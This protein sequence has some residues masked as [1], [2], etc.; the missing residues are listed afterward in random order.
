VFRDPLALD[1]PDPDHSSYEERYIIIGMTSRGRP[2]LIWYT[3]RGG[4]TRLI[5]WRKPT[6]GELNDYQEGRT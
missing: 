1:L 4:Q 6:R 5:G 3:E 2:L